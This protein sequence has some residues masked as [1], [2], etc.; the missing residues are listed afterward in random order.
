MTSA[1]E[2]ELARVKI[3]PAVIVIGCFMVAVGVRVFGRG[4]LILS[5]A[6]E[7]FE[8]CRYIGIALEIV[9]VSVLLISY[10]AMARAKTTIDPS[11][12][13]TTVVTSGLYAYSRN[14]IYLGW[15]LVIAG[16]GIRNA[17]WLLLVIAFAMLLLL[18][19]AVILAE[20]AYL[21]RKFKEEY[22]IYKQR[23]R[24]WL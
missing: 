12:Q 20:E 6:P 24:R 8:V 23:V 18:Y 4:F 15:F 5:L 11:Q 13:T 16:M 10:G 3:H 19:W 21:E 1:N 22:L 2:P 14:P 7:V 17:S 9:G